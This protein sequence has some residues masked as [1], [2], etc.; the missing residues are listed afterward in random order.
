MIHRTVFTS[1]TGLALLGLTMPGC[2]T[3]PE[4]R[5]DLQTAPALA[6]T[7]EHAGTHESHGR[8]GNHAGTDAHHEPGVNVHGASGR[9]Q[10]HAQPRIGEE[11]KDF[12][13]SDSSAKAFR[14]GGLRRTDD[15]KGKIAV[16]TFWCTTCH[17]CRGI[18]KGFAKKAREYDGQGV[19]FLM[20][21]SNASDNAERVSQFL[22]QH[23]LSFSV[24]MDS[25][26]E[27]AE[28][29]GAKLTT[30]TAVID[31][32]GRLRY[33]GG[34]GAAEDAVRNLIA[35]QEVAVPETPFAG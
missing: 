10:E 8:A 27:L 17:S 28:Y 2:S 14:L 22:A 4:N 34:Y 5:E 12:V 25:N 32:Q 20:V 6:G 1:W 33:Y 3:P 35:G 19:Q 23:D 21:D 29:F 31:A 11:I 16:L 15:A 9:P 13:L 18:E 24:V 7:E 26:A 30:T